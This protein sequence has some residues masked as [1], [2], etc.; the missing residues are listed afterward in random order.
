MIV[1]LYARKSTEQN[2]SHEEKSVTR[3]VA[4]GRGWLCFRGVREAGEHAAGARQRGSWP[5][6]GDFAG[7]GVLLRIPAGVGAPGL[8][9]PRISPV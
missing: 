2:V 9:S 3:Y 1:A 6:G 4:G 7:L 8:A 5:S